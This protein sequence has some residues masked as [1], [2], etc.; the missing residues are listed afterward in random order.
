MKTYLL[1]LLPLVLV[2]SQCKQKEIAD[3]KQSV[4]FVTQSTVDTVIT[5]LVAKYGESQKARIEKGIKQAATLWTAKDGKD[6]DFRDLCLKYFVGDP[7]KLNLLFSRL[8]TNF[9]QLFGR[10]NLI[11]LSMKWA[12][13]IDI[14]QMLDVDEIFGA[15]D[16]AAHFNDDFF[17]NKIA[18]ITCMNFPF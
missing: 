1:L 4:Q 13:H 8:Q 12:V 17:T 14:G 11:T 3:Q 5:V 2:I 10:Y 16:P 7:A 18:F 15:W 6:V 9:E